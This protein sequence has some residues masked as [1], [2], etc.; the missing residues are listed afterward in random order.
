MTGSGILTMLMFLALALFAYTQ[1][2]PRA[3][4]AHGGETMS[5]FKRTPTKGCALGMH[6][7]SFYHGCTAWAQSKY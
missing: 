7:S 3:R 4:A 5:L 6:Y 2:A 1:A